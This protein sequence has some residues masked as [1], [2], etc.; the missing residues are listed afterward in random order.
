MAKHSVGELTIREMSRLGNLARSKKVSPERRTE[1][2]RKAAQAR[3]AVKRNP[4]PDP[5]GP[6]SV[7][8]PISDATGITLNSRRGPKPC[9]NRR[10]TTRKSSAVYNLNLFVTEAELAAA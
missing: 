7:Q 10:S 3:W 9:H 5:N 8:R 4:E 2:A 6:E 1:I